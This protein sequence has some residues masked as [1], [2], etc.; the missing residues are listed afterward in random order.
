MF[1]EC[2]KCLFNILIHNLQQQPDML[3]I[4]MHISSSIDLLPA[5]CQGH[6]GLVSMAVWIWIKA[7]QA[8]KYIKLHFKC[9]NN[10][11]ALFFENYINSESN[12]SKLEQHQYPLKQLYLNK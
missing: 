7:T 12:N 4:K 10:T 11:V 6:G 2:L 8:K 5:V 9:Y 3:V 1:S